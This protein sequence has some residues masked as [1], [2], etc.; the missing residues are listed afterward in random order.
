MKNSKAKK[1][2]SI[3]TPVLWAITAAMWTVTACINSTDA[4]F[5]RFWLALQCATAVLSGGAAVVNYL[6][7]KRSNDDNDE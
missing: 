5:P 2:P 1:K 4:E 7:Y 3:I 6:K